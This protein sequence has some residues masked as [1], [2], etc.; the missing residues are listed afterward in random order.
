MAFGCCGVECTNFR[1]TSGQ[2]DNDRLAAIEAQLK[3]AGW[4]EEH[5]RQVKECNCPCHID[6]SIAVGLR[7]RDGTIYPPRDF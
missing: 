3:E 4:T 2:V 7:T 5:V 6:G 1:D